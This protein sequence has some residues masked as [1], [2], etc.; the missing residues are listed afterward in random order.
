VGKLLHSEETKAKAKPLFA[1]FHSFLTRNGE[2]SQIAKLEER[3]REAFLEDPR[4]S[5]SK[6]FTDEGFDPTS[7]RVLISPTT[8]TRPKSMPTIEPVPSAPNSPPT[9]YAQVTNSPKR[10]L[11][12]SDSDAVHPR[13]VARGESPL[14][15]AAGRR[16]DKQRRNLQSQG[17]PQFE[18][19]STTHPILPPPLPRGIGFLLSIIP[20]A[21][22]YHATKFSPEAMVRLIR[23]TNIAS[24]ASHGRPEAMPNGGGPPPI[25]PSQYINGQYPYNRSL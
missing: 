3:M 12:E 6:R 10:P 5:F 25:P 11:D 19:Q 8:Q 7:V 22:T 15:G 17:M 1:V 2:L 20:K 4:L 21:S 9:R 14:K 24:P 16:L 18:G 13:K 23:D